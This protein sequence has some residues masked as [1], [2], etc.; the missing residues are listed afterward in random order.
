MPYVVASVFL[1]VSSG[2][3]TWFASLRNA[4]LFLLGAGL[5]AALIRGHIGFTSAWRSFILE[6]DARA[7]AMMLVLFMLA[8]AVFIPTLA[9]NADTVANFAPAGYQPGHRQLYLRGRDATGTWL[10]LGHGV[11]R[12]L[13]FGAFLANPALLHNR[14]SSR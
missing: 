4:L 2:L 8:S 5:A 13:G 14:L 10:R 7:F 1:L 6:R 11:A 9:T 12:G 3:I